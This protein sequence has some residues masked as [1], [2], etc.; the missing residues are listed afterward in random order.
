MQDTDYMPALRELV[1]D[2]VC[3]FKLSE[4]FILPCLVLVLAADRTDGL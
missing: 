2:A 3:G 1:A 4:P